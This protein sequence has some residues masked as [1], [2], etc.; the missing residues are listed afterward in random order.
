MNDEIIISDNCARIEDST[1]IN[2]INCL[3]EGHNLLQQEVGR[4][5]DALMPAL[6]PM[7]NSCWPIPPQK[8]S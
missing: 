7:T 6:T 3:Q 8:I 5:R 1:F 4:D 2:A